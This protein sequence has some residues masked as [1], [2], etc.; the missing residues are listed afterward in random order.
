MSRDNNSN[1]GGVSFM[2]LLQIAFI[3][4]KLTGFINW[5]WFWVLTPLWI[6]MVL[7]LIIVFLS[8]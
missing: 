5:S 6:N 7:I 2:G 3:V 8:K 4:L 1:S